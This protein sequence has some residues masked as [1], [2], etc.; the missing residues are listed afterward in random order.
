MRDVPAQNAMSEWIRFEPPR[1]KG[2]LLHLGALVLLL[3]A[4]GAALTLI[5]R[6]QAGVLTILLL[7]IAVALSLGLPVLLYRLYALWQSGYWIGRAG[8]RIR[9]GMRQLVLPHDKISDYARA[10]ELEHVPA[11][12]PWTWPGALVGTVEDDE[13]GVVEFLAAEAEDLVLLGTEQRVYAISPQDARGFVAAYRQQVERGSLTRLKAQS[14]APSFP[15][16]EA[17]NEPVLRRLLAVGG[18]LV[19]LLFLLVAIFAPGRPAVSL[20]FSPSGAPLAPAPGAQLF[21]LPAVN[22]LFFVGS[23]LMGL[24]F[25][26][27]PG[28][29]MLTKLLWTSSLASGIL[30]FLAIII[31]L[32]RP[33]STL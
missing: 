27:Q 1:Q 15:L 4:I 6:A 8:L 16:A 22:F 29:L 14:V 21:L 20:G 9:W 13:L 5:T 18:N 32:L 25:Y 28:Q 33:V 10:S 23:L 3:I 17:W 31:I 11:L 26:R 19:V 24:F 7:L 30:I 2:L 12:P